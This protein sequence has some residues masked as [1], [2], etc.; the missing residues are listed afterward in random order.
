MT[1][2]EPQKYLWRRNSPHKGDTIYIYLNEKNEKIYGNIISNTNQK[3]SIKNSKYC[4]NAMKLLTSFKKLDL[5]DTL[6]LTDVNISEY[7]I[8]K[9]SWEGAS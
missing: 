5:S 6:G 9:E 2:I 4:G 7:W 8:L 3:G 1:E